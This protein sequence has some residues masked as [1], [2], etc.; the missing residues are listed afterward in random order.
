MVLLANKLLNLRNDQVMA[1]ITAIIERALI[2][3]GNNPMVGLLIL[4]A[5]AIGAAVWFLDRLVTNNDERLDQILKSC[6]PH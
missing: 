4:N 3:V 1:N 2:V 6:L 5:A